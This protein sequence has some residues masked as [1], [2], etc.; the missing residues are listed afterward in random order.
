MAGKDTGKQAQGSPLPWVAAAALALIYLVG[1][2]LGLGMELP[3]RDVPVAFKLAFGFLR[4][5]CWPLALAS[6]VFLASTAAGAALLRLVGCEPGDPVERLLFGAAAGL[7]LAA[8]ATLGL[9]VLGILDRGVFAGL[10][11]LMLIAG[12]VPLRQALGETARAAR[13]WLSSWSGFEWALAA[14][15]VALIALTCLCV[16]GP[17]ADY[18]ALEYHL[19]APGEY[20]RDGQ[21]GFLS[22]NVYAG[23]PQQVEMLYLLGMTLAGGKFPG[24]AVAIA[25]QVLLGALAAVA[26]GALA[27][28]YVRKDAA[29]PAATFFLTLP[30]VVRVVSNTY[31]TLALCFY[32]T[33]ALMAVL[34]WLWG[35][36]GDRRERIGY[37]VLCGICC[38]LAVAVKYTALLLLCLPL[39]LVVLAV[40]VRRPAGEG[41]LSRIGPAALLAACALAAV[42]PWLVRNLSATGNPVFPLLHDLFGARGWSPQQAAKFARAHAPPSLRVADMA[43]DTWRFLTGYVGG[44]Y[45]LYA[46]PLAVLFIPLLLLPLHAWITGD[47]RREAQLRGRSMVF[48]FAFQTA[49]VLLWAVATHRIARFL[50]PT[51]AVLCALSAGGLCAA[52][53]TGRPAR[54]LLRAVALAG[55][56]W[57]VYTQACWVYYSGGPG[58]L[59]AGDD[60]P[61]SLDNRGLPLYAESIRWINDRHN[62]PP[63]AVV[64]LVGEA[65]VYHFDR[66][67]LYAVV[68]NDHPIEPA[69]AA[70]RTDLA[71]GV[72]RL[73]RSGATHVL[74]NWSE[75]RRLARSYA[76]SYEG[77]ERAGCLP[78][79]ELASGQPLRAL[80]DAA[81]RRVMT[82]GQMPW[83]DDD[84]AGRMPMIE[85]YELRRATAQEG[86]QTPAP[87]APPGPDRTR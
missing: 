83:P 76:F 72:R 49:C 29:L 44:T 8:Y 35:G 34:G 9:G 1:W 6:I 80:L 33:L 27:G 50:A 54:K 48:L 39:G 19:G 26:A 55:V 15:G 7:G 30:M 4:L 3:P 62:V 14:A 41:W 16:T 60:V 20:F 74:V 25:M 67:V 75:L 69:L 2:L 51:L 13:A 10:V 23:F 52:A 47:G 24:M 40:S 28:R 36:Q 42:A 86:S 32:T 38:G 78:Q 17:V 64:M 66:R 70:A 21:V 56:L 82:R 81:G 68:F 43:L 46:G 58:V 65:R 61:T 5:L 71:E 87:P 84:S 22:H 18:D 12:Y 45:K 31:V 59:F 11:M 77:R 63:D 79:V 37:L 53:A 57:G 85:V 73:R